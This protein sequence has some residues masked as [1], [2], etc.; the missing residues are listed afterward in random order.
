MAD[1]VESF[2]EKARARG[3]SDV[4][5]RAKLLRKGWTQQQV[6]SALD[7]LEVPDP[8]GVNS[9]VATKVMPSSNDRPIAVV[10][11]LS[12]RGFEYSIMFLSL[13]AS[14]VAMII[15][16]INTINDIYDKTNGSY[17][18]G[19]G[20]SGSTLAITMLL[21]TFPVFAYMFLR[22][23]KAEYN[24]PDLRHDS[25]RRKWTQLT[26]LVS[27][28]SAVGFTIYF[29]YQL[30]SPESAG[31]TYFDEGNG[32]YSTSSTP[33]LQRFFQT[34]VSL[35]VSGTIFAYYWREDRKK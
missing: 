28:L 25:S 1:Q 15:L 5:I 13:W 8:P 18:Y 6:D 19:S 21:V 11:S 3:L 23:K 27:F 2:I 14:A 7:D 22:L 20:N 17:T 34:L 24:E 4:D 9:Q 35:V 31:S 12:V 26:M 30:I 32:T 10:Q 29:I 16:G 33:I